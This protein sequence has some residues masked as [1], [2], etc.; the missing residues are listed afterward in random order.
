MS[1]HDNAH[2]HKVRAIKTRL[3]KVGVDEL[4]QCVQ[5]PDLN[6]FDHL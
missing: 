5:G 3:A 2:V 1:Q 4:K 6:P